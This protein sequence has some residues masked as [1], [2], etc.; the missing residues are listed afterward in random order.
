MGAQSDRLM[1]IIKTQSEIAG[2]ELDSAQVMEL[3]A[4]RAQE[5]TSA[6][7]AVIEIPEGEEMVYTVTT[8]EATPYLG[9][10]LG[11]TTSL[12]GLSLTRNEVLYCADTETDARVD[13]EACKRVN[14]RSMICVP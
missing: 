3:V 2:S 12:S 11:A 1:A 4:R 7:A 13:R 10:R 6:T 14:A 9:T 8:G 5:I